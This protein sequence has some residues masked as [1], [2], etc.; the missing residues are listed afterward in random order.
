MTKDELDPVRDALAAR[1]HA[2]ARGLLQQHLPPAAPRAAN[3]RVVDYLGRLVDARDQTLQPQFE[4]VLAGFLATADPAGLSIR[5]F[6]HL[7]HARGTSAMLKGQY[8]IGLRLFDRVLVDDD[9]VGD[10]D[11][12]M[13]ATF[14]RARCLHH[15]GRYED[16]LQAARRAEALARQAER[17]A[18]LAVAQ[19]MSAWIVFKQGKAP[20]E[21]LLEAAGH[22]LRRADPLAHANLLA[23]RLR[24]ARRGGNHAG[25]IAFGEEAVAQYRSIDGLH[26]NLARTLVNL[27][28]TRGALALKGTDGDETSDAVQKI[29]LELDEAGAIYAQRPHRRGEGMLRLCEGYLELGLGG[30]EEARV[31][32]KDVVAIAYRSSSPEDADPLLRVRGFLLTAECAWAW[33][34]G[35]HTRRKPTARSIQ[36]CHEA[37]ACGEQAVAI[38]CGTQSRRLRGR[39][40]TWL[41]LSYLLLFRLMRSDAHVKSARQ[42]HQLAKGLLEARPGDYVWANLALLEDELEQEKVAR[43]LSL[44]DS[45]KEGS[46]TMRKL[47]GLF[48]AIV[49][50]YLHDE[51][52]TRKEIQDRL[53][54]RAAKLPRILGRAERQRLASARG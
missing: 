15:L 9:D 12:V 54:I 23:F 5:D 42:C 40:Y 18:A 48:E 49:V 45:A 17:P 41:G 10:A 13:A 32:A 1:N 7:T 44:L 26:R 35:G 30:Y 53:H 14:S 11:L 31:K 21:T 20:D 3:A 22:T 27:A 47:K 19:L 28:F 25:A 2:A 36:R 51:G 33:E 39:A 46:A 6:A 38:A 50:K 4:E 24:L 52:M 37:V 29:R 8:D 43:L 34:E 16:A